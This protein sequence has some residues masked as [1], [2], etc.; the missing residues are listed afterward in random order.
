[1]TFGK[2]DLKEKSHDFKDYIRKET[3]KTQALLEKS[4]GA[5]EWRNYAALLEQVREKI[6]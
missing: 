3:A 6:W 2:T 4:G 1:L 5:K